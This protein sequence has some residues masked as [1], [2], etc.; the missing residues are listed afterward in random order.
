MPVNSSGEFIRTGRVAAPPSG[1][2]SC[3]WIVAL[4]IVLGMPCDYLTE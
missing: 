3:G 1:G 2:S 4:F